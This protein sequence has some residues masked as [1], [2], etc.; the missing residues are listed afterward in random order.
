MLTN[1]EKSE[2]LSVAVAEVLR[3]KG[4]VIEG[5]SVLGADEWAEFHRLTSA[6]ETLRDLRQKLE[7]DADVC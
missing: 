5:K 3:A 6:A 2:A 7:L 4:K 1:A